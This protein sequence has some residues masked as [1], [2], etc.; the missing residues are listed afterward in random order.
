MGEAKTADIFEKID[1]EKVI[2]CKAEGSY[3]ILV[4][5]GG[6]EQL[7]TKRLGCLEK[8]FSCNNF[9][10]CHKSFLVN[11]DHVQTVQLNHQMNLIMS[12][13]HSVVVSHRKRADFYKFISDKFVILKCNKEVSSMKN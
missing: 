11:I 10:R 13:K 9:F 5:S 8:K 1:K 2:F 3:T 4:M 12:D 6:K 7:V